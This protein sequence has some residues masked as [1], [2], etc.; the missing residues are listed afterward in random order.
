M[1]IFFPNKRLY[2]IAIIGLSISILDSMYAG[3]Q[4]YRKDYKGDGVITDLSEGGIF[5]IKGY[6]ITFGAASL[7]WPIE[8][9]FELGEL[10]IVKKAVAKV[11]FIVEGGS[12]KEKWTENARL[13]MLVSTSGGKQ[14]V[15]A[16][17]QLSRY[18]W[19]TAP[20]GHK[21]NAIYDSEQLQ[22]TPKLGKSY[23]L[24]I[25]YTPGD[26]VPEMLGYPYI[27]YIEGGK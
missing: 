16:N 17:S 14:L 10:P 1:K 2:L 8:K 22:F 26:G 15:H 25:K 4:K 27:K 20:R 13:E 18:I 21:G 5:P 7:R 23:K 24:F 11:Y 12:S 6:S 9:S 19:S 3:D